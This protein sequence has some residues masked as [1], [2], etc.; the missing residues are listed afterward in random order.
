MFSRMTVAKRLIPSHAFAAIMP[1]PEGLSEL[2]FAGMLAGRRFR[3]AVDHMGHTI[4]ADAD[5]VITG[6][7]MKNTK[8][9]VGPFGDHL[10]Y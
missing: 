6:T 8:K 1:M 5:F 10:G 3:Y 7:I 4:S 2:T 9:P